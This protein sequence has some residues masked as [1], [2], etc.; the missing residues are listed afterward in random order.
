MSTS[1]IFKSAVGAVALGAA[2]LSALRDASR[3]TMPGGG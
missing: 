2:L 3:W 1:L